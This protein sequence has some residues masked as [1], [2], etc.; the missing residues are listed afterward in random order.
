MKDPWEDIL[1]CIPETVDGPRDFNGMCNSQRII[2]REDDGG[3]FRK[4]TIASADLLT[5]VLQVPRGLQ[6]RRHSMKLATVMR[7]LDWERPDS[8]R[9]TI[10]G[11]QVRGYFRRVPWVPLG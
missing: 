3:G 6:E 2:H 7:L 9:V 8:Q 1:A 10:N 5:Y 4:E 11:K